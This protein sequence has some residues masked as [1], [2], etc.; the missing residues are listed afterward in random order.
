MVHYSH[1][2]GC[3]VWSVAPWITVLSWHTLFTKRLIYYKFT[4]V[5]Y[6]VKQ[7]TMHRPMSHLAHCVPFLWL[8]EEQRWQHSWVRWPVFV[9]ATSAETCYCCR[10]RRRHRRCC[11]CSNYSSKSLA[12]APDSDVVSA[13]RISLMASSSSFIFFPSCGSETYNCLLYLHYIWP[14]RVAETLHL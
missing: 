5:W 7:G 11:C 1:N 9:V 2:S 13:T 4:F 10:R 6:S 8:W 14:A 12:S 3:C